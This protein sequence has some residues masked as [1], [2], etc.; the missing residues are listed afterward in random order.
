MG[1]RNLELTV[2]LI[3]VAMTVLFHFVDPQEF[4][5]NLGYASLATLSLV[6]LVRIVLR[7]RAGG[8]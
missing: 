4:L 5:R 3:A 1:T 7:G 8:E 2:L 6:E